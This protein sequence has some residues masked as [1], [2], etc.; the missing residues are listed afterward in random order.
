MTFETSS[1]YGLVATKILL[2]Y[3]GFSSRLAQTKKKGIKRTIFLYDKATEENWN[4]YKRKLQ[5]LLKK[6]LNKKL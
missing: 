3:L 6:K 5:Y 1:D 2:D 4:S